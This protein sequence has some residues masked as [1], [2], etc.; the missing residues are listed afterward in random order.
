MTDLTKLDD[1]NDPYFK[2]FGQVP[3]SDVEKEITMEKTPEQMTIE[4]R[5]KDTLAPKETLAEL[6]I[7]AGGVS[8]QADLPEISTPLEG[9]VLDMVIEKWKEEFPEQT[10]AEITQNPW[11]KP[12][13]TAAFYAV[14]TNILNL[15]RDTHFKEY[16]TEL[17]TRIGLVD[18]AKANASLTIES[19]NLQAREKYIEAIQSGISAGFS[20]IQVFATAHN[21]GKAKETYDNELKTRQGRV[22]QQA[23]DDGIQL[24]DDNAPLPQITDSAMLKQRRQELDTWITQE[25]YE[26]QKNAQYLSQYETQ[27]RFQILEQLN[28]TVG[29]VLQ[30]G[31]K[32]EMGFVESQKQMNEGYM[33]ALNKYNDTSAKS[34]DDAK[35]DFD[36][37]LDFLNRLIDAEFKAHALG[38]SA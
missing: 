10:V 7:Y 8:L 38:H 30:G 17:Q 16:E 3:E 28:K 1:Q 20:T 13:Y 25:A 2:E 37:F 23:I 5:K 9:L 27:P 18:M 14:M 33:Q 36:R 29:S 12:S 31:I 32:T 15:K 11:F 34:R 19:Y 4:S 26:I 24:V 21:Y 22:R 6:S 35:A